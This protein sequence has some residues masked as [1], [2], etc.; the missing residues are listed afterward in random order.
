MARKKPK[1]DPHIRPLIKSHRSVL[2]VIPSGIRDEA[3]LLEAKEQGIDARVDYN[4]EAKTITV[5]LLKEP[6]VAETETEGK[7]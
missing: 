1:K 3:H 5:R 4:T 7:A 2:I 6:I